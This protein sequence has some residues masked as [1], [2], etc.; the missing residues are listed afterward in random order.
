[1]SEERT[2]LD[3]AQIEERKVIERAHWAEVAFAFALMFYA[4]LAVFAYRYAY[5]SWDISLDRAIQSI[6]LPG[7]RMLMAGISALGSGWPPFA[8]VILAGTALIVKRYR[9]E[10]IICMIEVGAGTVV[11]NFF[12]AVV[13]RPRPIEPL[14]KVTTLV[15]RES[16]PSGHVV[17]FVEFFGFLL[18][19]NYAIEGRDTLRRLLNVLLWPLV[20]LVGVSRVYL[21]AHWPSD[22]VGAYLAGGV[23]LMLTIEVYRRLKIR[24]GASD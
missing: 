19:L 23:W 7:F 5:F 24:A 20:L 21:G 11:N 2:N 14:V 18:F 1:M 13:G 6:S 22:V 15:T 10:G 12:K 3:A 9:L 8:L 17:F 4:A 16:F